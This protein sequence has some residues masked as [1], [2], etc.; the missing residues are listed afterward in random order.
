MEHYEA[1]VKH[2]YIERQKKHFLL[3]QN[4]TTESTKTFMIVLDIAEE[5]CTCSDEHFKKLLPIFEEF[6]S[7]VGDAGA[8]IE[9]IKKQRKDKGDRV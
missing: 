9:F 1:I 2:P 8:E 5:L 7:L 3:L 4:A 6:Y